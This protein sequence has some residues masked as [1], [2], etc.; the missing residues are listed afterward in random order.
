MNYNERLV[1]RGEILISKD[2]VGNWDKELAA[3]NRGK[4]G[5]PYRYPESFMRMAA[6]AM[7]Y[8]RLPYRQME[9]LLR[10]YGSIPM[11][12]DYTTVHK[13]VCA[14]AA[15]LEGNA[16]SRRKDGAVILAI[17]STG[18]SVTNRGQWM[19]TKWV[20][21]RKE[22]YRRFLK[23]HVAADAETG[24]VVAARITDGS[25]PDCGQLKGLVS[26][27]ASACGRISKVLADGAYD[28]RDIFS[29]L[30]T[31]GIDA[32]IPVH[33]NSVPEANRD[34]PARMHA[35]Y[36]Q[37]P[38]ACDRWRHSVSYGQR[39]AVESVFSVLKRMFGEAVRSRNKRN[40]VTELLLK[41]GLYN[42]FVAAA[43]A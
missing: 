26:G 9:G 22:A 38:G 42:R 15:S 21:G 29:F 6:Y 25:S 5:R 40:M 32:A 18:I 35:V 14:M 13:R 24:T 17:D 27:A 36:M 1:R 8:F 37:H 33:K 3:M 39:W 2:V 30:N 34:C 20:R 28:S 10:S 4:C 12:P 7:F 23:I 31:E 43:A 16:G 11:A 41:M 19:R